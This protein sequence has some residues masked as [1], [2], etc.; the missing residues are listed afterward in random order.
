MMVVG[1]NLLF[2]NWVLG[3]VAALEVG[4]FPA[5]TVVLENSFNGAPNK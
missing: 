1:R 5:A 4:C 2:V 3:A